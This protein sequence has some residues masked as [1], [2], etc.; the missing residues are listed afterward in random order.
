MK[1]WYIIPHWL[2]PIGLLQILM[3]TMLGW[4]TVISIVIMSASIKVTTTTSRHPIWCVSLIVAILCWCRN[5]VTFIFIDT[6]VPA[7]PHSSRFTFF[8]VV[9]EIL[10]IHRFDVVLPACIAAFMFH[11]FGDNHKRRVFRAWCNVH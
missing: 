6:V 8:F 7:T 3:P 11:Q 2:I 4:W 1:W 9:G 5:C 10:C